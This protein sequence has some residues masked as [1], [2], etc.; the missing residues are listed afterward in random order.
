M[1]VFSMIGYGDQE[2]MYSST[3]T[4]HLMKCRDRAWFG[5][6]RNIRSIQFPMVSAL[7]ARVESGGV[8]PRARKWLGPHSS[9]TRAAP[10]YYHNYRN[11]YSMVRHL[12]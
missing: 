12:V 5:G 8:M 11:Y 9:A 7:A 6:Y 1:P 2:A 10:S 3:R 4:I